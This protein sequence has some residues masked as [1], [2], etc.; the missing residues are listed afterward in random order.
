MKRQHKWADMIRQWLD[1]DSL[2]VEMLTPYGNWIEDRHPFWEESETYRLKPK[3]IKVGEHEFPEPMRV[4]P[5]YGSDYYVV[6]I[7]SHRYISFEIW[8]CSPAEKW[9]LSRGLCHLTI[10]A[11]EAHAR[12]LI[13][14]T[15]VKE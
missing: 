11:A 9:W 5:E 13:A 14:L 2:V 10:E 1:D 3:M 4:E 12:A 7:L 15:E 8:R 6:G